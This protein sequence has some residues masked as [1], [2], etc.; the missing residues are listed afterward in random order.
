MRREAE[1]VCDQH[2]DRFDCPDTL[3][4]YSPKLREYG[5][6]V[7]DGGSSIREISFCPWCGARL[8]ASLRDRW[9][10]ELERLGV[11]PGG[12]EIPEAYRS[13]DWWA[14]SRPP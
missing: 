2:P 11:D 10:E 1:F 8:P 14:R 12:E 13:S 6:I 5:L 3:L 7:H 4:D 9:F